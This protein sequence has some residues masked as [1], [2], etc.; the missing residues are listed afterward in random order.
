MPYHL[1]K[2]PWV[3][4][5]EDLLN[6]NDQLGQILP[7]LTEPDQF[8]DAIR[9]FIGHRLLTEELGGDEEARYQHMVSHWFG[10]DGK[11]RQASFAESLQVEDKQAAIEEAVKL[12]HAAH[13]ND[14]TA[15]GKWAQTGFWMQYYGNVQEIVRTTLCKA[16]EVSRGIDLSAGETL[17]NQ[18]RQV[19]IDGLW[20]CGQAWWEG[21]LT[22]RA[23]GDDRGSVTMMFA[24]PGTGSPILETAE[25]GRNAKK[26]PATGGGTGNGTR[27]SAPEVT[28]LEQGMWVI[29]HQTNITLPPIRSSRPTPLGQWDS[30]VP[31][32]GPSYAGIGPIVVVAPSYQDGGAPSLPGSTSTEQAAS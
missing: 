27:T 5:L 24:T 19:P 21:W 12:R 4:A 17:E 1:E 23:L 29:T 28:S 20:K 14:P 32:I 25:D 6:D 11:S 13:C 2:G 16:I 22:W 8:L 9:S 18:R 26:N 3:Y 30:I 15:S 31:D 7:Y 10:T